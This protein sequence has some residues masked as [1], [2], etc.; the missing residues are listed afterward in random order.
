MIEDNAET[1][2][3]NG[4]PAGEVREPGVG[5]RHITRELERI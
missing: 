4:L 1:E 2:V 3:E 5:W